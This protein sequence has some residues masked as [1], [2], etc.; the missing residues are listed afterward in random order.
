VTVP[1][2]AA[3]K[4]SDAEVPDLGLRRGRT[5]TYGDRV[6]RSCFFSTG[7][8]PI[9]HGLFFTTGQKPPLLLSHMQLKKSKKIGNNAINFDMSRMGQILSRSLSNL[10]Y[11]ELTD[12]VTERAHDRHSWAG[13]E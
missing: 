13:F 1:I 12:P 8:L 11:L 4:F 2:W 3:D 5:D 9:F 10:R 6:L 7:Q